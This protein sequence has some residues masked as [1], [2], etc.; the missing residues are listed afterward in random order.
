ML[1]LCL[2]A[3]HG[4]TPSPGLVFHREKGVSR[5]IKQECQTLLPS[6][7]I[8]NDMVQTG[9]FDLK[10][11]GI[12]EQPKPVTLLCEP[13]LI[14][15]VDPKAQK[16]M[17]IDKPDTALF[18]SG[19]AE[20]CTRH[21]KLLK[22]LVSGS[23]DVD[24]GEL[25]LSL[26]SDLI[27]PLMFGV[28]QQPYASLIY[29]SSEFDDQKPLPDIVG[30][31]VQDSKL[32]VNSDGLVVFT[33][34]GTEMKDIL[35]IVAEF[36]L[37]S[38]S[39][40]SRRQSGLVPYF[41]RTRSKKVHA[42]TSLAPKYE[43][44]S[45]A[46]PKSPEKI[47]P[48]PSPKRKMSKK[49]T[50][51]RNLYKANYFHACESLLSLM[52]NKHRHGKMAI[53]SLKKSGPELPQLLTQFSAGIA[54]TGLAVVLSVFCKVAYARAPLCTSNLFSTSLGF[55]LVWLSW[56]VNRLRDTIENISK[57]T[58]KLDMKEKEMIKRVEKSVDDIYIR[59][60]TLM[61]AAMLRFV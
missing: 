40:K 39:T 17:A 12:K 14:V 2:M 19:I 13:K 49:S 21:E 48:K 53:L 47:K 56:A 22:F 38:N 7:A 25:D 31:M 59:A 54:G 3:S 29:P 30:E 52:V 45:V 8:K 43:V 41:N 28:H 4:Y 51:E 46:P 57:N 44:A 27:E 15:D 5:M 34:S 20:K 16:P 60:A 9:P 18:G 1:K 50:R 32:I 33:S 26:L 10:C 58:G 24:K 11:N 42:S 36:H 55:G 35:S 23:K 6:K 37:S 61:A